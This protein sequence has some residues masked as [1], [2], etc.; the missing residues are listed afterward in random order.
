[1]IKTLYQIGKEISAGRDP[2]QDILAPPKLSPKDEEKSLYILPIEFDLDTG[3]VTVSKDQLEEY[4]KDSRRALKELRS[5]KIQGGNNKSIYV[6]VDAGKLE[7]LS[8]TLFGKADKRGQYPE[9]GEFLEAIDKF[10]PQSGGTTLCK[11]LEEIPKCRASFLELFQDDKGKLSISKATE[12]FGVGRHQKIVLAYAVVSSQELGLERQHLG[13][14]EGYEAFIERKFFPEEEAGGK[15][16]L[17]YATGEWRE[18]V[19]EAEFSGRYNINK[20]FVK[21]TQ[22]Y[23]SGFN[24]KNYV[25]N[26]QLSNEVET[27]LDRGSDYLLENAVTEIAGIRHVIIPEFFQQEQINIINLK[28]ISERTELLFK[29]K[30]WEEILSYLEW[31]TET[32]GLYWLTFIAIDTDREKNYFKVGSQIKDVSKL[33]LQNVFEAVKEAGQLFRPWLGS[34]YGFNLYSVYKSIPVR[35]EKEKHQRS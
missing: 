27:Y 25:R 18:D 16:K 19:R 10:A 12:D 5:L 26:Y 31:N 11:V 34:R 20:F 1:M 17:C 21:T 7:Q 24:K 3:E 33:H 29:L 15:E 28:R 6:A 32:D 8:K 13:H 9:R 30:T 22:N 35:K 2:W 14:L 23:A 4:P